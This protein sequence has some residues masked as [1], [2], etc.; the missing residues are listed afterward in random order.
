VNNHADDATDC[1]S[2]VKTGTKVEWG[3][4][5]KFKLINTCSYPVEA[6]WCANTKACEGHAG[7]LWTIGAGRDYPI[8]FADESAPDIRVGAC[9]VQSQRTSKVDVV[10]DGRGAG[11]ID[12]SH[13]PPQPAP[14][15]SIMQ[16]HSC[17]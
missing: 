6:A 7:N 1:L 16:D 15:V 2:V 3:T 13:K 8:F 4:S 11:Q 10:A 12:T 9:R 14:G 5:G 17:D